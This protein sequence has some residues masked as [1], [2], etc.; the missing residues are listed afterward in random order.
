VLISIEVRV[1]DTPPPVSEGFFSHLP[2]QVDF[3]LTTALRSG[4]D[5][6]LMASD[7]KY[8]FTCFLVDCTLSFENY[9]FASWV[10]LLVFFFSWHLSCSLYILDI[11]PLLEV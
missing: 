11:N 10:Y 7:V 2:Q 3:L 5:F 1:L 6:S 9:L 8:L 4:V